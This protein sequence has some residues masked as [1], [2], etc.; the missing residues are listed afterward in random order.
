MLEQATYS[1]KDRSPI[2]KDFYKEVSEKKKIARGA[3]Y[4]KGGSKSKKCSM[5]TDY[6]TQKQ[7]K[8]RNGP[9]MSY[10]MNQPIDWESFKKMSP[11][12]QQLYLEGLCNKYHATKTNLASMFQVNVATLHRVITQNGLQLNFG[13]GKKMNA[14]E[15]E[16]W[17][18]FLGVSSTETEEPE[19]VAETEEEI[20]GVQD[21]SD[22]ETK[23][24]FDGQDEAQTENK[25]HDSPCCMDKFSVTFSGKIDIDMVANSLRTILG[26][27]SVGSLEIVYTR[28]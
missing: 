6:M 19:T 26:N 5:S 21:N 23:V 22:K 15:K 3:R 16:A 9:I 18:E 1:Q 28:S 4:R 20:T 8:E 17:N 7:W 10:A 13:V 11:D 14:A 2:M 24:E 25:E 12:L 27:D